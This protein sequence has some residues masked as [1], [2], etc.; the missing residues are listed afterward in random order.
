MSHYVY[1]YVHEGE[2]IY[3]GKCDAILKNRIYQHRLEDKF[4]PFSMIK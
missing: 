3:I 1:K 4:K 2:I